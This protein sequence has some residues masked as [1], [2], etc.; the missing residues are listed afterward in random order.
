MEDSA[1]IFFKELLRKFDSI[2]ALWITDLEGGLIISSTKNEKFEEDSD[3]Q[4]KIKMSLSFLFN[5]AIDQISKIEK[6]KTKHLVSFFDRVT[7]FQSKLNKTV[8]AH[9]ICDSKGFNYEIMKEISTEIGEKLQ[10]I[11]KE[12]DALTQSSENI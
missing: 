11:E 4:T 8:L 6:W 5:S 10:K 12:I 2:N 7:V 1:N 3:K 9:F